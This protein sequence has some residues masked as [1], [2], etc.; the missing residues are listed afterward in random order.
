MRDKVYL[1]GVDISLGA[2]IK[3]PLLVVTSMLAS[4][5]QSRVRSRR[6]RLGL[7][8][9]QIPYI[10]HTTYSGWSNSD[11]LSAETNILLDHHSFFAQFSGTEPFML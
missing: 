4:L 6:P 7:G 2:A 9:A 1:D 3:F 5:F 11:S 10:M 8:V